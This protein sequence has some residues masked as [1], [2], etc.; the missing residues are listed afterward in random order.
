MGGRHTGRLVATGENGGVTRVLLRHYRITRQ[1]WV[2]VTAEAVQLCLP[3]YFGKDTVWSIPKGQVR[4]LDDRV[5]APAAPGSDQPWAT[6]RPVHIPYAA[7]TSQNTSPNLV[8]VFDRPVRV[9]PV[10]F[11]AGLDPAFSWRKSRSPE[12]LWLDGVMLRAMDGFAAPSVLGS[13]G[14][15]AVPDLGEFLRTHREVRAG[16]AEVDR[17]E[18]S[19]ARAERWTDAL[20]LLGLGGMIG[21]RAWHLDWLFV[22]CGLLC[23]ASWVVPRWL[24]R[25]SRD[26]WTGPRKRGRL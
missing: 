26:R 13:A 23:L 5:P 2:E 15:A 14:V 19:E 9:P 20:Y 4:V 6:T 18:S 7:T 17:I 11:I 22:V 8:L 16:A 25:G 21:S 24:R 12:G 10:R 3:S 1:P